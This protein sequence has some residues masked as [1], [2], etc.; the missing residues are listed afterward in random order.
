[1]NAFVNDGRALVILLLL[2]CLT[3]KNLPL[4]VRLA[5]A[6]LLEPRYFLSSGVISPIATG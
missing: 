3:N 6:L 1:M 2:N 4:D 5:R